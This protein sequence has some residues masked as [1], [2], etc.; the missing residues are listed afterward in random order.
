MIVTDLDGTLL[1]TDKTI[2]EY[3]KAVLSRCR[4]AGVKVVY[5]T[6]RG[7]SAEQ[8]A[9]P[10]LF[11]GRIYMNGAVA[12]VDDKAVYYHLIPYKTARPIL[13]ACNERGMKIASENGSA[14]YSNFAV[15]D[16]W[17][18]ITNYKIVDFSRH[19]VD[20]EKIYMPNPT[21]EDVSFI[22]QLLP[23]D[24]YFVAIADINGALGLI[25]HK[26]ATKANAAAALAKLWGIPMSEVAAFGD[27]YNDAEM[28][29]E[30]GIGVAVT[31]AVPEIKAA[32]NYLC[33]DCDEDGVA[34]WI[35]GNIL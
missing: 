1:R 12:K 8:I 10:E 9:P 3:T 15:S 5:A 18:Y 24:L 16:L 29:R 33:G 34:R 20:A 17:P 13:T 31:N 21:P 35:E 14:H 25:M 22:E 27:D 23:D 4:I 28:M 7:S 30:C 6:G 2:S 26:D 32:S 11:D 19:D